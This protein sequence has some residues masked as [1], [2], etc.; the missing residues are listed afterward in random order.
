MTPEVLLVSLGTGSGGVLTVDAINAL[1]KA[2]LIIYPCSQKG[3]GRAWELLETLGV[4]DKGTGYNLPMKPD[5]SEALGVYAAMAQ[6]AETAVI[7]GKSVA[8]AVEGDAGVF[9]SMHYVAELLGERNIR[10][11]QLPGIPS[12][13]AA[14]AMAGLHLVSGEERLVVIP[15]NASCREL[16]DYYNSGHNIVVMKASRG[17]MAIREFMEKHPR[18]EIHY[19][20]NVTSPDQCHLADQ[21]E[22]SVAEFPYFSLVIIL[23]PRN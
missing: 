9:A 17:K 4:V 18:A 13:I 23:Q 21:Q 8:I 12:F 6:E 20:E 15:G 19:F 11:S 2:D 5:R 7:A 14:S 22:I 16:E 1:K 10:V 3:K